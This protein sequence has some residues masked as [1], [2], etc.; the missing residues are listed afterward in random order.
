VALCEDLTARA[1]QLAEKV[2]EQISS[3]GEAVSSQ[4]QSTHNLAVDQSEQ[5]VRAQ[6]RLSVAQYDTRRELD[7]LRGVIQDTARK[8]KH[9][10]V[11]HEFELTEMQGKRKQ[12]MID[13]YRDPKLEKYKFQ[14]H[15]FA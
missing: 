2:I 10:Q 6:S 8:T 9:V 5:A 4:W 15:E 12:S 1:D 7:E 13:P 14:I 11:A 3:T